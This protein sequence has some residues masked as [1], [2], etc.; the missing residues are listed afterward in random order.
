MHGTHI[1]IREWFWAAYLVST[2]T[3]GISAKQLQRQIGC[4]YQT[5]WFLL[6]RLRRAMVNEA[7]LKLRGFVEADETIVGGP[8]SGKRGRAVTDLNTKTLVFGAVEVISYT[9]KDGTCAQK[10]GRIRLATAPN[11]NEESI[12]QFLVQNV[13]KGSHIRTDGWRGY[14][15][16]A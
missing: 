1:P 8:V 7:R 5:A 15:K 3:P 6:H 11:A 16:S 9:E 2:L 10:A 13:E 4:R 14:S 12:E